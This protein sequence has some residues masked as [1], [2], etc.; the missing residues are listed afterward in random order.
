MYRVAEVER[1]APSRLVSAVLDA[2][3]QEGSKS[4]GTSVVETHH[5]PSKDEAQNTCG[6]ADA[7]K[8]G[9]QGS[10]TEAGLPP[11]D[12]GGYPSHSPLPPIPRTLTG[13]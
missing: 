10:G 12:I 5:G 1:R 2:L 8:W 11:A 6:G 3:V 9:I 4:A 7:R 13:K